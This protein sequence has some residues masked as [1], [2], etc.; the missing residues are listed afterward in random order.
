[1]KRTYIQSNE[2]KVG[3]FILIP[4]GVLIILVMLKLGYSVASST[5]DVYLKVDSLTSVKKGT[6]VK[7]KGFQI[8]R[9]ADVR[10][11]FKPAL[12]F[13]ATL[14]LNKEI[15]LLE[16][17]SAIITNQNVIG[18]AVIKINNPEKKGNLLLPGDVIEAIEYSN[19]VETLQKVNILI[20]SLTGTVGDIKQITMDNRYN[21]R[22]MFTNLANSVSSLNKILTNSQNDILL[23]VENFRKTAV[24]LHAISKELK[25][26][27]VKFLF[28]DSK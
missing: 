7:I 26:H 27:P 14:R 11:V 28:K 15:L 8:G 13:L 1:M 9:V 24:M 10:P 25:K 20:S 19:L 6:P 3:L 22:S 18:D 2:L 23:T 17:C 12:H 5:M 16:D 4:M 21:L